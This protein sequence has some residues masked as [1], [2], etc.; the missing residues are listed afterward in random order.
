MNGALGRRAGLVAPLFSCPSSRSWGIGEIPDLPALTAWMAGAGLRALQMLPV[1][2]MAA[3]EQSPYASMS[4]MA[5]DPLYVGL[6][7]VEDFAALGGEAALPA[8]DRRA[9]D[10]ARRSPRV[11]YALIRPIKDRA[12]AAAFERFFAAEWQTGGHRADQLGHFIA[13]EAWWID[14]YALYR[15]LHH[16]QGERPWTTWPGG[17][18]MRDD[19]AIRDARRRLGRAMLFRQ[20]VQWQAAR[21]WRA[22]RA[23]AGGVAWLG[24]L[25][26][27]VAGDSADV[28]ARQA[29]FRFDLS[30]GVPPD[31]F[32]ATGQ[33]WGLP[34]YRWDAMRADGFAWL[35]ERS[36][37][38]AALFDGYRIDHLVGFYRTYGWPVDGGAAGFTPLAEADQL[39]LGEQVLGVFGEGG[40]A[41]FAEDLG[42][43]PDFV[44]ASLARLGVPGFRVLRWEREWKEPGAPFRDPAAY[45]ARSVAAS[46]THDTETMAEWWGEAPPDEREALAKIPGVAARVGHGDVT[47][48]PFG[49]GVRD[50]LLETLYGSG[51]DL[52]LLP[53]QDLFGWR[54]R[55]NTPATID[56]ANWTCRLPWPVD[57]LGAAPEAVERQRTLRVWAERYGRL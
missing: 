11:E 19:D 6:A 32:S 39:A 25:P 55:I 33:N 12:L 24:D 50:A 47:H 14:Q 34:V 38:A 53:V 57:R 3:D 40:A 4:A 46:G 35:R 2:E 45:P 10:D 1:N 41:I 27:M 8:E 52:L 56:A 42:T 22:A 49:P 36:R 51:S 5:I 17:L 48:E 18:A 21:Q 28:W 15:A 30:L 54:D 26:F 7:D 23:A 20:Y 16:E 44:R 43:V 37:R 13:E 9:L 31:A 29:Q